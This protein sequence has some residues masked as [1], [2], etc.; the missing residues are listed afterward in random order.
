MPQSTGRWSR[1]GALALAAGLAC[2]LG[3]LGGVGG[4]GGVAGAP[5]E[6]EV[7]GGA[8]AVAG[9]AVGVGVGG[10]W[11]QPRGGPAPRVDTLASHFGFA[12]PRTLVIDQDAGPVIVGDFNADGRPDLAVVNNRKSRVELHLLRAEPKNQAEVER[13]I[14][15]NQL[16]PS[17]F[18]DRADISVPNRVNALRAHDLNGDGRLD[19]IMVGDQPDEIITVLQSAPGQFAGPNRQR[20]RDLAVS[21]QGGFHV[22]DVMGDPAAEI[23]TIVGDRLAVVPIGPTGDLGSP[24]SI[25]SAGRPLGMVLGDF[26]GDARTDIIGA[27]FQEGQ[28]PLRLWLQR[29]GA[30]AAG[31]DSAGKGAA[32]DQA[33]GTRGAGLGLI[34]PEQRLEIAPIRSA[35]AVTLPG[36]GATALGVIESTT[37]RVV[38]YTLDDSAPGLAGQE[39]TAAPAE[40]QAEIFGFPDG[41]DKKRPALVADFD[42][43]GRPDLLTTDE[44]SNALVLYQQDQ[45]LGLGRAQ[46]FPT[47]KAPQAIAHA[48]A[49]AWGGPDEAVF[50][51]LSD[52][53]KAVGAARYTLSLGRARADNAVGFPVPVRLATAGAQP[54]AIDYA[55]LGGPGA[56][57]VVVRNR[58]EHTLELHG[59]DGP[60]RSIPLA[61]V[62]RPPQS[63]L[64]ADVDQDGAKDLILFTDGEPMIVVRSSG[65][66]PLTDPAVEA[67]V[68]TSE[69]MPQ[70]GLVQSATA[71]NVGLMDQDGDGKPE[72]ILADKNFVRAC[73]YDVAKG[74]SVVS[75]RNVPDAGTNLVALAVDASG[76]APVA[77]AADSGNGV[78]VFFEPRDAP[79]RVRLRGVSPNNLFAG[80]F[81]GDGRPALL[82][83]TDDA[84]GLVR[85][86][87]AGARLTELAVYRSESDDREEFNLASGD[88]NGDGHTD[89]LVTDAGEQMLSVLTFSRSRRVR[90]ATEFQVYQSR[91]FQGGQ[92]RE[93]E[94]RDVLVADVTGDNAQ[95][96]VLLIHDRLVIYPQQTA[97]ARPPER[98][99]R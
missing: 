18:Y 17:P 3:A 91:L 51:V 67:Q 56:L 52:E 46:S 35:E 87:G 41:E 43:D 97:P 6:G 10:D 75:Q 24:T 14:K 79:R 1:S 49:G 45:G 82:G 19:L 29:R 34:G 80:A 13:E 54:V 78:L 5:D 38:F 89:V 7:G 16:R 55:D 12:A 95:D 88:I 86:S 68:L 44:K 58:R 53:E 31:P 99:S 25:S 69:T 90:L 22:A 11:A 61:G 65:A 42:Q 77:V 70:F 83:L 73:R 28:T 39:P 94:P 92:F 50:F 4:P 62:N 72:L 40:L 30:P 9:A 32:A 57:A 20:L 93:L 98:V 59:K 60:M 74:W 96:V 36:L 27:F 81:L 2:G 26:N 47:F 85:L 48:P 15:T 63:M 84:F 37:R 33:A 76:P 66:G 21:Q 23:V 71:R 8:G 64:A